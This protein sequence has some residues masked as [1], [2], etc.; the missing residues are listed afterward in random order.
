VNRLED[1]ADRRAVIRCA[2]LFYQLYG[3]I[4]HA[5]P[6]DEAAAGPQPATLKRSAL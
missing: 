5:L 4:F 6:L 1:P 2:N 3:G